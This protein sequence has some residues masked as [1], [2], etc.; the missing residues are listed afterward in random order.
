MEA[1]IDRIENPFLYKYLRLAAGFGL[2]ALLGAVGCAKQDASPVAVRTALAY[3]IPAT[4]G[5]ENDVYAG[6]IRARVEA[7]HAFRVGGKMTQRLVDAGAVVKKGQA[8]ARIDAQDV[9]LAADASKSQVAAQLTEA[10]FA[11]AELKRYQ[12]LFNK[13]FVSK[14]ALDQKVNVANAAK[15]RLDAAR[16]QSSVS[17]NQTG[18]ATLTAETSGVVTQV[19]A[20]SGQVVAAGQAVM[21][22]AN[23]QE[24]ELSISV[25][26][27]K[28]GDFK[29]KGAAP[30]DIRVALWSNP[31]KYYKAKVREIGGSADP[32]TRTYA[33]R[34]SLVE[35]DE[36]IQLGMSAYA[37]FGG[38][39]ESDALAVPLSA[40]YVR[41][42]TTGVWQIATDG[43]VALRP[44]SVVQYRETSA[45]IKAANGS[46]KAG[47]TIVAAGV[48]K[49]REG[50]IVKP[51]VDPTVTG[52]G[53]VATAPAVQ[54]EPETKQSLAFLDRL[55]GK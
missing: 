19:M 22:I 31:G 4:T 10:D 9:R 16:S 5:I 34:V 13:G 43:K 3:K 50:E 54:P 42:K 39:Y 55:F 17:I 8:L 53:K 38:A 7:D 35:L 41:D 11:D 25:P 49:L 46:V 30:R 15:A 6:D 28:L 51:I 20:E 24:K 12:D 26:E 27:A 37:V 18:Y 36:S 47:D 40:L 48:H 21:K 32:V 52:D 23:P 1:P 2:V 45:I 44:V 29:G 33:V 14:S